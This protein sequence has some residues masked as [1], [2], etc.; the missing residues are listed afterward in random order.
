[1]NEKSLRDVRAIRQQAVGEGD[2]LNRSA[3]KR[4][5]SRMR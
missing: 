5:M 2:A 1:M 4:V 3:M